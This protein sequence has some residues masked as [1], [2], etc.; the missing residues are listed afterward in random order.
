MLNIS[1]EN[2]EQYRQQNIVLCSFRRCKYQPKMTMLCDWA[3]ETKFI[4]VGD[5]S[6]RKPI[7]IFFFHCYNQPIT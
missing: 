1:V 2:I 7:S 6:I 3:F 4:S 5:S